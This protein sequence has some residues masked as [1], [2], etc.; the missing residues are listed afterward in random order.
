MAQR[1]GRGQGCQSHLI[2]MQG[3]DIGE[4]NVHGWEETCDVYTTGHYTLD[5]P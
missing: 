1:V 2:M 5:F 3:P 4:W